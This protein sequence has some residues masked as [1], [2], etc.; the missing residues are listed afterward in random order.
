MERKY[1]HSDK[2]L[3]AFTE[4]SAKASNFFNNR[5]KYHYQYHTSKILVECEKHGIS[6]QSKKH[7]LNSAWCPGC[8]GSAKSKQ[9][10]AITKFIES[11]LSLTTQSR[12]RT[13]IK[14][15][16]LDIFVKSKSVAIEY[17]G[18][19][20]HSTSNDNDYRHLVKTIQCEAVNVR[21]LHIFEDEW[22]YKQDIVKSRLR[23]ILGKTSNRI[24]A[25]SCEI[26]TVSTD[27]AKNFLSRTHI[28]GYLNSVVKLGLLFNDKLVACMTF[29]KPRLATGYNKSNNNSDCHYWELARF[30]TELDT[31]VIGGASK[32]LAHFIKTH[33]VDK[34][35]SYA[36][37]RWSTGGLYKTLGFEFSHN[38][39]PNYFYV[40]GSVRESR[41]KYQKWRLVEAGYDKSMTEHEIMQK[42]G[43]SR[44]YDCGTSKWVLTVNN[45]S[46]HE[47]LLL[48]SDDTFL[49][50]D[51]S[52]II[53]R[54]KHKAVKHKRKNRTK[55]EA[56]KKYPQLAS[57]LQITKAGTKVELDIY[58][59]CRSSTDRA[60]KLYD[61]LLANNN[62]ITQ[63]GVVSEIILSANSVNDYE[64]DYSLHKNSRLWH[65]NEEPELFKQIVVNHQHVTTIYDYYDGDISKCKK[66]LTRLCEDSK[67]TENSNRFK[68]GNLIQLR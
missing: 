33:E 2:K 62:K 57:M 11:E 12:N 28:Q 37:R 1:V 40:N 4:W 15:K 63:K 31:V 59:F 3:L 34:I 48:H 25:R 52:D 41:L 14:P 22:L 39:K 8:K 29:T 53:D 60:L 45:H 56:I 5:F 20:W 49:E 36:D 32:L 24:Y 16:E 23:A 35:F 67:Y 58:D 26:V 66:L 51:D 42:L 64:I 6:E 18:L 21:L 68:Q 44:I 9:E 38:S 54:T 13:L 27:D 47:L 43:Y 61:K 7:H 30:S 65:A 50:I 55:L 46:K 10:L 17:N 19:Y